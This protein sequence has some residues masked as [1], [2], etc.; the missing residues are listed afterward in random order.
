MPM[1][2]LIEE[3]KM[4]KFQSITNTE[5]FED[6]HGTSPYLPGDHVVITEKID[7]ANAS[8]QK[9]HKDAFY[10][11]S[12]AEE[13][14]PEK[15]LSGFYHAIAE[16]LGEAELNP[17]Y[18]YYGEWLSNHKVIYEEEDKKQFYL[19]DVQQVD[20]GIYLAHADVLQ[21]A[22]E[23]GLRHAPVL[24]DGILPDTPEAVE[25]L[26]QSFVGK[27]EMNATLSHKKRGIIPM[28]EGIVVRNFSRTRPDGKRI[29]TKIVVDELAESRYNR[30]CKEPTNVP[31]TAFAVAHMTENRIEKMLMKLVDEDILSER[32]TL[33]EAKAKISYLVERVVSDVLQEHPVPEEFE[34][35]TIVKLLKKR[36]GGL[37]FPLLIS[38]QSKIEPE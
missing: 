3:S 13:L 20:T 12:R 38:N 26:I 31:E 30:E 28:G 11:Y 29:I 23:L 17:N 6:R 19:Y 37:A 14:S 18:R 24:F 4:I 8:F 10:R 7:G 9:P 36:A 15:T 16:L 2:T 25:A 32:W 1:T 34:I 27:T 33:P 21:I 35:E 22:G 5:Y